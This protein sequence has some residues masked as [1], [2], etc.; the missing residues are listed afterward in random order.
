MARRVRVNRSLSSPRIRARLR[1]A[2]SR[3]M[4]VRLTRGATPYVRGGWPGAACRLARAGLVRPATACPSKPTFRAAVTPPVQ[5]VAES[6]VFSA[7]TSG[8]D[9]DQLSKLSRPFDGQASGLASRARVVPFLVTPP[10]AV[11]VTTRRQKEG[12]PVIP[13]ENVPG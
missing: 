8:W 4:T 13:N 2:V 11:V 1:K 9:P 6:G 12:Q 5:P 7:L 3:T 10:S